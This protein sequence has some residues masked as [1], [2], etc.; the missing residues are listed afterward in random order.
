[1]LDDWLEMGVLIPTGV[2]GVYG[3]SALFEQVAVA[4]G[5]LVMQFGQQERAEVFRFPPVMARSHFEA[6]GFFRNFADLVGTVHCFCGD[7]E[8]H[9]SLV[10]AHDVGEDWTTAQVPSDLVLV[11]A[12]C[13]PIYPAIAQRGPVSIGGKVVDAAGYCFRRE[14][15]CSPGRMQTFR[16]HERIFIGTEAGALSFRTQWLERAKSMARVLDLPH[17]IE[18]AND[19]FFGRV[20]RVMERSQ[21]EHQLKLEMLLPLTTDSSTAACVSFNLHLSK[22]AEAFG[23]V[24]ENGEPAFTACVGFGL[25]RLVLAI[26]RRHGANPR[27]WPDALRLRVESLND[28]FP[29]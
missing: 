2:E 16:Q 23:L 19:P 9:R 7:E 11:P 24:L 1:M 29:T 25:E 6:S 10:R 21:R 18:V 27:H 22:M 3:R 17:V 26:L 14:S 20:G 15:S 5:M 28:F 12:V 8:T 4:V 13:Y